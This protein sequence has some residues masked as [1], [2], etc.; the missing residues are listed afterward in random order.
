MNFNL[1]KNKNFIDTIVL[2]SF[3]FNFCVIFL[4][5]LLLIIGL[6][7]LCVTFVENGIYEFIKNF[8]IVLIFI[9]PFSFI[10]KGWIVYFKKGKNV[11]RWLVFS[12]VL[13][14][15]LMCVLLAFNSID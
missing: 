10:I 5:S 2:I 13:S 14:I 7:S 4:Y 11:F 12:N 1:I 6:L 15:V 8:F 3:L 9:C